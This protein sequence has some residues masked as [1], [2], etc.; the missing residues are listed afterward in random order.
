MKQKEVS[1]KVLESFAVIVLM[2]SAGL[3]GTS[4][5]GYEYR[6][7]CHSKDLDPSLEIN[8]TF[9]LNEGMTGFGHVDLKKGNDDGDQYSDVKFYR[10]MWTSDRL[11][12]YLRGET[13]EQH[14]IIIV[15]DFFAND[16]FALRSRSGAIQ[17]E[18][19]SSG[20]TCYNR[21]CSECFD[22]PYPSDHCREVCGCTSSFCGAW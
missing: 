1:L 5:M 14:A 2:L 6:F 18:Y 21:S 19:G 3:M 4:A 11:N 8:G 20:L 16:R 9:I 13:G 15:E 22:E 7:M 10:G 17:G 12:F